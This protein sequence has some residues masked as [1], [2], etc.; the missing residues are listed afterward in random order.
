MSNH[1]APNSCGVSVWTSVELTLARTKTNKLGIG[2]MSLKQSS[3]FAGVRA[4]HPS[5]THHEVHM[6][7]GLPG[8]VA[9]PTTII[10]TITPNTVITT[11]TITGITTTIATIAT[12]T[13]TTASIIGIATITTTITTTVITTIIITTITIATITAT[14]TATHP[15]ERAEQRLLPLIDQGGLHP[16]SPGPQTGRN[17]PECPTTSHPI[18]AESRFGPRSN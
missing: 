3:T 5:H 1:I 10:T 8:A 2:N 15:L 16:G 9:Q 17:T 4:P 7:L 14:I 13:T 18:H 11:N 6:E 12:T